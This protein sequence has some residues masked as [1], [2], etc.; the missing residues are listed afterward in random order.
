METNESGFSINELQAMMK[1]ID[2][3][4]T[5]LQGLVTAEDDKMLRYKVGVEQNIRKRADHFILCLFFFCASL[6]FLSLS[7]HLQ[8]EQKSPDL[9]ELLPSF[10]V[11]F[12]QSTVLPVFYAKKYTSAKR[13]ADWVIVSANTLGMLRLTI[14]MLLNQSLDISTSRTI[15][16][17][18]WRFVAFLSI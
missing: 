12:H 9:S 8:R 5:R 1:N 10:L 18:T 6:S 14:K 3:E 2:G 15:L 4:I 17:N 11:H 13:A 16:K 7:F